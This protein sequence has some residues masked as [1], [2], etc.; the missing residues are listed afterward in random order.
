[1]GSASLREA[2]ASSGLGGQPPER[3]ESGILEKWAGEPRSFGGGV[4][5]NVTKLGNQQ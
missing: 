3:P 1:M 2:E 5:A 4:G